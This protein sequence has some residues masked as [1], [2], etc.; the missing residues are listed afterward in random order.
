MTCGYSPADDRWL[1]AIDQ[2]SLAQRRLLTRGSRQSGKKGSETH[3]VTGTVTFPESGPPETSR[4]RCFCR[5]FDV[6]EGADHDATTTAPPPTTM[7]TV[8]AI[9]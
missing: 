4:R 1:T 8:A 9:L 2:W 5:S 6:L 3:P 7:K